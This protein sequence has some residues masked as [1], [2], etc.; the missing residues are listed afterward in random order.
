MLYNATIFCDIDGV[1]I[2]TGLEEEGFDEFFT[3]D[4]GYMP[5]SIDGA[6]KQ[7]LNWHRKGHQIILTTGRPEYL[8]EVTEY[9][10]RVNHIFF[11]RLIMGVGCGPRVLINDTHNEKPKAFAINI[12]RN[13]KMGDNDEF[14]RLFL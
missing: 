4:M 9:T 12:K 10:L 1:L 6:A 13:Q 7:T 14:R 8:R 5:P 2:Q 3:P 11:D